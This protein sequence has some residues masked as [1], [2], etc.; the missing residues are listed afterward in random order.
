MNAYDEM[1]LEKGRVV[2]A[3]MLDYAVYDLHYDIGEIWHMFLC[4]DSARR[5]AEGDFTILVG[6]SGVELAFD[7]V[8]YG[9]GRYPEVTPT[10]VEERSAEYWT[11]WALAYY[12]W[13]TSLHF[14]EITR[15]V[16]IQDVRAL[17]S[18]YHEMDIRQFTDKMNELYLQQ[19]KGTNLKNRRKRLEMSQK[20][21][22]EAS[23]VPLR[24]I[25]QYEQCQKDINKANGESLM[26]LA[27]TLGCSMED[28]MEKVKV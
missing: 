7:V 17:Y 27:R 26:R 11:G 16:P 24:S 1:Y 20:E 9:T 19:K 8:H 3:R 18:P 14:D 22:A 12:Q 13:T 4:S 21:L 2:L 6:K 5:F 10:F 15:Y 23:G 25:Q 28:I